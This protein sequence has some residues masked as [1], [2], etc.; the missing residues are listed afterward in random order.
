MTVLRKRALSSPEA[1]ARSLERR[2]EL[3]R[4][5]Q[6]APQ[7]LTLFDDESVKD[8]EEPLAALGA[9]GLADERREQRWL[10]QL[11]AA[12]RNAPDAKRHY[13]VR[14]LRRLRGEAAIV[15][16]EYRDTLRQ[17]AASLPDCLMLHGGMTPG[18][19]A[20]VQARFNEYGGVLLAT[21]AGSEGLN[22]QRR[23]RL[24]LCYE[25]P[26]NPARLEQRIGRVDR[27]G[28]ARRVHAI[29]LVARDTAEDLVIARLARRLARVAATLGDHDRL[30][31]FLT[32]A[33][34]AGI[35][36]GGAPEEPPDSPPLPRI[37]VGPVTTRTAIEE[38]H[39]LSN[40]A[41]DRVRPRDGCVRVSSVRATAVLPEGFVFVFASCAIDDDGRSVD[42]HPA[43][44]HARASHIG[45]PHGRAHTRALAEEAIRRYQQYALQI[46]EPIGAIRLSEVRVVH[47]AI[48][49]RAIARELELRDWNTVV[50]EL[51]PGLF[52]RRLV[53]RAE[54]D[55][56][57]RQHV[58]RDHDQRIAA[59]SRARVLSTS[60]DLVA[61]LIVYGHTTT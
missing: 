37:T 16:T 38:A 51:Q 18:E 59:L 48:V 50:V 3:L 42:A 56:S 28:Q 53:S 24:V 19:R 15:F 31:G 32:D 43:L 49:D 20:E 26:W 55:L 29:T 22:L 47:S 25:L 8:D 41:I 46:A 6:P 30:A 60:C 14:L 54:E 7:Q 23:C 27:L 57:R 10:S 4:G 2:R 44:V 11:A 1:V 40:R 58:R 9:P 33:R 61:M 17:L 36:I 5:Q 12:A 52:D 45:R 13:L 35:V 39:R 34:T 21:D